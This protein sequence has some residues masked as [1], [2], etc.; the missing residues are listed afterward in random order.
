MKNQ[1]D[2]VLRVFP[3]T[4]RDNR[5]GQEEAF[6]LPI[7]KQQLQAAQV[8]GQSSKELLERLCAKQGYVLLETGIPDR[9]SITL[10]LGKL[11]EQYD[12]EQDE[13]NKWN[14]LNGIDGEAVAHGV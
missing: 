5:T 12:T 4:V 7:A 2:I 1:I 9:R 3:V 13:R 8:V 14:Y 10:D 6:M 11:L